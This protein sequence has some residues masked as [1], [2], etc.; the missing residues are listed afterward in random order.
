MRLSTR[1]KSKGIDVELRRL[2][3]P[4]YPNRK[5]K[6][7]EVDTE[8][9]CAVFC[10]CVFEGTK[11]FVRGEGIT[12]GGT[13]VSLSLTLDAETE[14]CAPDYSIYPD[15]DYSIGFISRGCIR[16]CYFCKVPEKEG[17][18]RQVANPSDIIKHKSVKFLDNNFLALPNHKAILN[19]LVIKNVKFEFSQGLDIRLLDEENSELLRRSNYSAE[20]SFA[21]DDLS[22]ISIIEAKLKLLAWRKPWQVRFF[23]YIH[24]KMKPAN[25]VRRIEW[26]RENGVLPYV[27]RDIACWGESIS[28][29]AT[30][31]GAWC[32]QPGLFKNMDF[33]QFCH[34]RHKNRIRAEESI[35][36]WNQN[37]GALEGL[38]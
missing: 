30:D 7:V 5:K 4:Y 16:K 8:G 21:F 10:S 17:E 15:C 34:K 1:L 32:N 19:D 24:P 33:A 38:I 22:E 9:Y 2:N 26:Q 11:D 3:L 27:M 6:A 35:K 23:T 13:G 20:V 29:M 28:D 18:L 31:L 14:K 36:L 37:C 25:F 12:F